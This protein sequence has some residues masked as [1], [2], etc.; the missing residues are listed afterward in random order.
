MTLK[1]SNLIPFRDE[2]QTKSHVT[3]EISF[4]ECHTSERHFAFRF[5]YTKSAIE[6]AFLL[7]MSEL[8]SAI[9]E[10]P[11]ASGSIGQ[12]HRAEL[13]SAGAAITGRFFNSKLLMEGSV[14]ACSAD[15]QCWCP[16]PLASRV[17]AHHQLYNGQRE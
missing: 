3:S 11:V 15:L 9:D 6:N 1:E 14:D 16:A 5:Q 12:V 4:Y 2:T 7:P 17:P 13:A 8:F 10:E